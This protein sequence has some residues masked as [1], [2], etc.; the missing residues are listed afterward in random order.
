MEKMFSKGKKIEKSTKEKKNKKL[1][2]V[3]LSFHGWVDA[4]VIPM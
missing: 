3:E 4:Q 1:V 2:F